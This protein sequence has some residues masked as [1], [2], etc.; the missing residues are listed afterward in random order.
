MLIATYYAD[1]HTFF[2]EAIALSFVL[3]VISF[4][5]LLSQWVGVIMCLIPSQ[6]CQISID[7]DQVSDKLKH[8]SSSISSCSSDSFRGVG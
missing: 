4:K 2:L 1:W 8:D 5:E 6:L 3:R 7:S